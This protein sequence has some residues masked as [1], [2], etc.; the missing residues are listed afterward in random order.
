MITKSNI[1]MFT[2]KRYTKLKYDGFEKNLTLKQR[3][4]DGWHWQF[5]FENGWVVSVIK[6]MFSYGG[7]H[8]LFEAMQY[9]K[10]EVCEADIFGDMSND[11]VLKLL[12]L[13]K[14]LR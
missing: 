8:N 13:T 5:E 10:Q 4:Y 14:S 7:K 2:N 11:E 1:N 9:K 6:H 12:R 3:L